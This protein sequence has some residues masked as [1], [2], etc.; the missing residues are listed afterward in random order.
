MAGMQHAASNDSSLC[1]VLCA[2]PHPKYV[3]ALWA[4]NCGLQ[5]A[6]EKAFVHA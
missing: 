3:H 6:A 5:T 2:S 1:V 4:V